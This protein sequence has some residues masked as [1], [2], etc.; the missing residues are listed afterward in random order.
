MSAAVQTLAINAAPPRAIASNAQ[1]IGVIALVPDRWQHIAHTTRHH[2]LRRLANHFPVIWVEPP[3]YWR[4]VIKHPVKSWR[5]SVAP[6]STERFRILQQSLLYPRV[7][8]PET[9]GRWVERLRLRRARRMLERLGAR[10][11]V[12]YVWRPE[13]ADALDALEHD[14][15]CYHVDDEYSFST[16]DGPTSSTEAGLIERVDQ[17]F[18]TSPSL[19]AKKGPRHP[20][21]MLIPNGVDFHAYTQPRSEPV[22]LSRI[23]RP[24]VGYIG[25]IKQQLDLALMADLARRQSTLSFVFVGPK[26]LVGD[27]SRWLAELE[28]LPNCYFLGPK[29]VEELPGYVQH[30][31]VC[32]LCY[33]IDGYTRYIYPLKLHEYLAGGRPVVAAPI[34][35][36]REFTGVVSIARSVDEW[37]ALLMRAL[38]PESQSASAQDVRRNIA[39]QFDWNEL[40][41][42][43]ADTITVRLAESSKSR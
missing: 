3:L 21:S 20:H 6:A 28:S 2:V 30:L 35:S 14:L 4:D 43:I 25:V 34:E 37:S 19:A 18:F 10:R 12:L 26:G 39:S 13:S 27:Q 1:G 7:Y 32:T 33:K 42:K 15:S 29:P 8:S 38:A 17:L 9:L 31:N 11:I 36:L 22:D 41:A 5:Q 23:P 40:V 24:R 16:V